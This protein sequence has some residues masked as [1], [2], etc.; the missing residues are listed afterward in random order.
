LQGEFTWSECHVLA[1]DEQ[2]EIFTIKWVDTGALKH[3]KR[4]NLL[5]SHESRSAFRRRLQLARRRRSEFETLRTFQ[6]FVSQQPFTNQPL[7]HTMLVERLMCWAPPKQIN[8]AKTFFGA[9]AGPG[10]EF[11]EELGRDYEFAVKRSIVE[12]S[13]RNGTG[14]EMLASAEVCFR[15]S[16][17]LYAVFWVSLMIILRLTNISHML[18]ESPLFKVQ[19]CDSLHQSVDTIKLPPERLSSYLG[20]LASS[21]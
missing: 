5:F 10:V 18:Q 21:C 16:T 13:A 9:K 2:E 7:N 8:L 20:S 15:L 11:L 14:A 17:V 12:W 6:R 3:V 1:Y 4:L 19:W